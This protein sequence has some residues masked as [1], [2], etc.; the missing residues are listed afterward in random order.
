MPG[1]EG[2]GSG[3]K[4]PALEITPKIGCSVSCAYCPQDK[5][6]AAYGKRSDIF[7][8]TFD[9]FKACLDKVPLNVDIIFSGMCEP[10]LNQDCSK[11][12]L[13]AH[14][15][16]HKVGVDTTLVGMSLSDINRLERIPFRY[17]GVHLPSKEAKERIKV[18][19][20]YLA[21]LDKI[22]KSNIKVF[23]KFHGNSVHPEVKP[24]I[25]N[26][27]W[28]HLVTRAGNLKI[29]SRSHPKLKKGVIGCRRNLCWNVLLPNGDVLLC[30]SDYGIQHVLGNL[31]LSDYDSLFHSEEFFKVKKGLGD[32]SIDILCRYCDTFVYNKGFFQKPFY[33]WQKI[34]NNADS[35]HDFS[36]FFRKVAKSAF[37]QFLRK[38]KEDNLNLKE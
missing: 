29:K 28:V 16:G 4:M 34:I 11:M 38:G 9:K 5:L 2:T 19:S 21:L 27:H 33:Y 36:Y 13:Y 6:I 8:L 37:R 26:I 1:P 14:E 35:L 17:F 30:S 25:A 15:C 23:Y 20:N 18:D 12:I 7:Q 10:F 24:T 3:S 31:L 22:S 32:E